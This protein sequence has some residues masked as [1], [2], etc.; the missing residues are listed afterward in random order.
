MRGTKQPRASPLAYQPLRA[1]ALA[2]ALASGLDAPRLYRRRRRRTAISEGFLG[3]SPSDATQGERHCQGQQG[4]P[5]G[6]FGRHQKDD[7]KPHAAGHVQRDPQEWVS[8]P[9]LRFD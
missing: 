7:A 4:S 9:G 1:S 6:W 3:Q 5:K 2:S 8:D